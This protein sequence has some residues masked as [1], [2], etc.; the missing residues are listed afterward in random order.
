MEFYAATEAPTDEQGLRC[1][2]SRLGGVVRFVVFSGLLAIPPVLGW[3]FR[4]PWLIWLGAAV[5]SGVL[6]M[7]LVDLA[8]MFRATNWLLFIGRDGLWVNLRSYRDKG[9]ADVSVVRFEYGEISTVGRHAERY[10]T[11]SKMA[12]AGSQGDVGGSTLW[13]DE[14]LEIRLNQ[15]QTDEL[16]TALDN[17]RF[18]PASEQPFASRPRLRMG[19]VPVVWLVSP[20]VLRVTWISG[21]GP[22][23][24]PSL[25]RTLFELATHVRIAEPTQRQR[26]DWRKLPA[27]D[28][29]QLAR[30]LIHAHSAYGEALTLLVRAGGVAYADAQTLVQRMGAEW[31]EFTDDSH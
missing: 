26:P 4:Q 19:Y 30:E 14:F 31:P 12:G 28:V 16:K 9:W 6:L 18:Q 7:L 23:I 5:A 15:E 29:G 17:L 8:A 25:E 2:Q 13:K 10:S 11:P 27:D 24:R 20:S 3:H 21:H 1:R 22:L